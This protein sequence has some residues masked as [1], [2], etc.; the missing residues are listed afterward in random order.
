MVATK[1]RWA[2]YKSMSVLNSACG[3]RTS[4]KTRAP[5]RHTCVE[6]A[7]DDALGE[8]LIDRLEVGQALQLFFRHADFVLALDLGD[9]LD[10]HHRVDAELGER[11]LVRDLVDLTDLGDDR[12][13]LIFEL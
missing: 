9:D 4:T 8:Q 13:Q 3:A 5:G 11:R 12:T 7:L 6:P 2:A 1:A 10:R